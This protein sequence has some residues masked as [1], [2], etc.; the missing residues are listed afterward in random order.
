MSDKQVKT[1]DN[2]TDQVS[3]REGRLQ[4]LQAYRDAGEVPFKYNFEPSH[5]NTQIRELYGTLQAGDH[6]GVSVS[7]A[8]RLVAKRGHGKATFGN[9]L[10]SSD[11]MQ[12]YA[13]IMYFLHKVA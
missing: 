1:E 12:Y 4:K 11:G 5:L 6:S 9:V 3:E 13:N 10:D 2:A 8:G 7:I